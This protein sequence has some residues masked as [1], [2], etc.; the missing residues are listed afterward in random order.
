MTEYHPPA[1]LDPDV[2]AAVAGIAVTA[3]RALGLRDM[4]RTDVIVTAD[5]VVEYL[6]TNVS[7]GMTPTS[8]LPLAAAAADI[9]LG[10]LC[11]D[12]LQ[13]AAARGMS[14]PGAPA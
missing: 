14:A 1:R 13:R 10:T 4:S 5:G 2:A 8:L 6:E 11:R 12:L 9:D 3:P 7:P